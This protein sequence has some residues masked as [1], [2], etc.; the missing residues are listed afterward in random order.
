MGYL[1]MQMAQGLDSTVVPLPGIEVTIDK[2][3]TVKRDVMISVA[4]STELAVAD[5]TFHYLG[6][7]KAGGRSEAVVKGDGTIRGRKGEGS[8]LSGKMEVT[9]Y[10]DVESGQ[11][12]AATTRVDVD[13]DLTEDGGS[14]S[15]SGVY[16][17]R[18]RPATKSA[19]KGPAPKPQAKP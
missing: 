16:S 13:L 5:L 14:G 6:V 17:V 15:V 9:S 1:V 10:V 12:A 8:N 11:I 18:L 3:W 4:G 19:V 7:R 2:P